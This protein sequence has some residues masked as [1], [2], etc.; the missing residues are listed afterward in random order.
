MQ[1]RIQEI[2][3]GGSEAESPG[4]RDLRVWSVQ[5]LTIFEDFSATQ[6]SSIWG[7]I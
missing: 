6:N 4:V 3:T 2:L 5:R 1:G 7:H